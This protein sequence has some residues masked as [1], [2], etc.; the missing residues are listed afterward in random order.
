MSPRPQDVTG[1][2]TDPEVAAAGDDAEL[3]E[4]LAQLDDVLPD[5]GVAACELIAAAAPA[6][7]RPPRLADVEAALAAI[8]LTTLEGTDTPDRVRNLAARARQPDPDGDPV[9]SVSCPRVAA[10]CVY[11][12]LVAVAADEL[13]GTGVRV[14]SVAG[15]FPSGRSTLATRLADTRDALEAGADEIDMVID[16]GA[17]LDGRYGKVVADVAA[18][19]RACDEH[20]PGIHLKVIL[21]TGELGT[22]RS[23]RAAGWLALLAGADV[24]KTSTGKTAPAATPESAAVLMHT[25][26]TWND[27]VGARAGVKVAGGVRTTD[28]A[29]GYLA[30]TRA[31]G[32][33]VTPDVFRI[34]ASALLDALVATRRTLLA[35]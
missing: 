13:A 26:R 7:T 1:A 15:A 8:D 24:L 23:M 17:F 18:V 14:A 2:V 33:P 12:D 19:R 10:V 29:L 21:E 31:A 35:S 20:R 4:V 22:P 25:V 16:R 9:A 11:P 34:G 6:A 5:A 32:L 28:D 30:L 3:A 27:A